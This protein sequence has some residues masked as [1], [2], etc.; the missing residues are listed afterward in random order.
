[1]SY[2]T[3]PVEVRERVAVRPALLSCYGCRLKLNAGLEEVVVLSTCNRMEVYG[4]AQWV[5]GKVQR[6]FEQFCPDLDITPYVYVKEG[7]EAVEHLFSVTSGLDS[8]VIGE[9]EIA[10]QIKNA[11]LAAQEAKLTGS[12]LNRLFQTALKPARKSAPTLPS[13]V[14]PRQ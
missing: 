14:A 1:M 7:A 3:A 5:Q 8:M 12:V 11:Y 2:K 10:G 13:A 4:T 6:I 9:T